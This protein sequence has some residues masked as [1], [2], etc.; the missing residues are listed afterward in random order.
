MSERCLIKKK[1]KSGTITKK[2]KKIV[3][4]NSSASKKRCGYKLRTKKGLTRKET[5]HITS[6]YQFSKKSKVTV[7]V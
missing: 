5:Y 3:G 6:R 4:N 7:P 2:K 1:I